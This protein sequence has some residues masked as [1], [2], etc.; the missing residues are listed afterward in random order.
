MGMAGGPMGPGAMG[1]SGPDMA[2]MRMK[3]GMGAGP[4][5]GMPG[6]MAGAMPGGGMGAGAAGKVGGNPN[7]GLDT[8]VADFSNPTGAVR[9]FLSALKAKDLDRL[10][11][12]TAL[13]AS[14]EASV[15]NQDLFQKIIDLELSDSDLDDLAK[16]LDGY[17]VAGVST[18]QKS[19]GKIGVIVR[20]TG[21]GAGYTQR[22]V[23]VR[24]EKKGWGVL[25]IGGPQEF[26]TLGAPRKK[27]Y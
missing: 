13:R 20:K 24:K 27:N 5:G 7:A 12:S 26:K 1:N 15:K 23:T 9:S 8:A 25:D 21:P 3:A 16:K 4:P 6:A 14:R 18:M 17:S 10:S 11:E 22:T 2:K 19:T